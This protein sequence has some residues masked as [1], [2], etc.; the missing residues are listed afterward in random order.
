MVEK[1]KNW[2]RRHWILSSIGGLFILL[3]LIGIFA[4]DKEPTT[5]NDVNSNQES[6]V[7]TTNYIIEIT[8]TEGLEFSGSIGGGTNSKSI[9][10]SIPA[11]YEVSDWPAVAV[12]Q[13][14]ETSGTLTVTIKKN[15]RILNTQTTSASYGVVTVSSN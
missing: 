6:K 8:G 3:I 7:T 1:N 5:I 12:I 11:T 15:G 14:K 10:G 13:K 4:G 2:F 9:E